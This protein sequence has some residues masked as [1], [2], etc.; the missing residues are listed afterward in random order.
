M[1][2]R[3]M[4]GKLLAAL[5]SFAIGGLTG[6]IV[7]LGFQVLP[8]INL[9][10]DPTVFHLHEFLATIVIIFLIVSLVGFLTSSARKS[11]KLRFMLRFR[12][13]VLVGVLTMFIPVLGISIGA[14]G[15]ESLWQF[16]LAG[17]IGGGVWSVPFIVADSKST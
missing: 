6:L 8:D 13:V 1:K 7:A 3:P 16:G 10:G 12:S 11:S 5:P 4:L 14:S 15:S 9:G 17:I 2:I